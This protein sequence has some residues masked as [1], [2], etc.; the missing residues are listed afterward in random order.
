M[1][2]SE[3]IASARMGVI[4]ASPFF[5]SLLMR[6]QMERDDS[7][8]TFCTNGRAI[9]YNEDFA[10]SLS[11]AELRG[12]LVHCAQ[13]HL[14]RM[15]QRDLKRWNVATDYAINNFLTAFV[16]EEAEA[17]R[18]ANVAYFPPWEL[19]KGGLLDPQYS[20]MCSEEI[21]NRLPKNPEAETGRGRD[22][23]KGTGGA[24]SPSLPTSKSPS[25][26]PSCGEFE[27]PP[28]DGDGDGDN[29]STLNPQPS[30]L[31]T[32]W[33]VAV[34]QAATVAK[35]R[36]N[37]PA[38]IARMIGELLEPKVPWRQVLREFIRQRARDDYSWQR[39]NR[40]YLHQGVVLP[41]LYSERMGR[42][43]FGVDTSGSIDKET[44]TE[45]AAEIQAA[46][47]ECQPEAMEVIYCDAAVNGTR[48]FLPG[49]AV[50][51]E[52]LGGGGTRFAPVFEHIEKM[53]EPP[54]CCIYLTDGHGSFPPNEPDYPVL[55]AWRDRLSLK[56]PLFPFGEM[57]AVK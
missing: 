23:K 53:D 36:G 49:D 25:P 6:L 14:W 31:Q 22:G 42:I 43:V 56:P 15:G 24:S 16:A 7:K 38:S 28:K 8:P 29:V 51:L 52:M 44:L 40:R 32:D 21:Y 26:A 33:Q 10:A 13:G 46:L 3:R 50:K 41:S 4:L 45:F 48:E 9:K 34:T 39:A 20:G 47:D 37:L 19:P 27:Q 54:V 17:A 5:G 2:Q 35:M 57:V 1:N 11:D 30:T 55:W 18:L 12:V